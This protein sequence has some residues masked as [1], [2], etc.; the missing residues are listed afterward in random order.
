ME[1]IVTAAPL[2]GPV[3][4]IVG[5]MGSFRLIGGSGLVDRNHGGRSGSALIARP[6]SHYRPIAL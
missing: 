3:G 2:L 4:T 6:R 5:M 1:T